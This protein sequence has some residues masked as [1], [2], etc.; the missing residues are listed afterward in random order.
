MIEANNELIA[1]EGV[2]LRSW[3]GPGTEHTVLGR[4]AFY[5]DEVDGEVLHEWVADL[6]AGDDVDDVRC[7]VCR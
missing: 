1:S 4:D 2:D 7:S 3:I 6:V 5:T